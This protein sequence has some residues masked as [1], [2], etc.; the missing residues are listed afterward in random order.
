M[1]GYSGTMTDQL[2]RNQYFK[3]FY[4]AILNDMAKHGTR[5]SFAGISSASAPT[6]ELT[7]SGGQYVLTLTDT[8]N[9]LSDY[10]V[11]DSAGLNCSIKQ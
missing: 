7:Y 1:S 3:A 6:Y 2:T 4:D 5:P 11:T 8:N 10:H 9:V